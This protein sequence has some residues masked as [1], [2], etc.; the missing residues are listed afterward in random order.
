MRNIYD[1]I[2][3]FYEQEP[4]WDEI[5]ARSHVESYIRQLAW[6]GKS[7]EELNKIWDD[8]TIFSVYLANSE[9]F[10]GDMNRE[11][12]IDCVAW[13]TRNIAGRV[14][15]YET[16]ER[17]LT[18]VEAFYQ[19]LAKKKVVRNQQAISDAKFRMLADNKVNYIDEEGNVL[20]QFKQSNIY[21]TSDL[22][23]KIFMNLGE[24]MSQVQQRMSAFLMDEEYES[25]YSRA[26]W[27][28]SGFMEDNE[29]N[30][31]LDQSGDLAM[32]SLDYYLYDY[33]MLTNDKRPIEVYYESAKAGRYGTFSKAA[34]ELLEILTE[35]RPI[36][37]SI[38]NCLEEG[39]YE[40]KEFFSGE[41]FPLMLPIEGE[42]KVSDFKGVLFY[43]H[44]Y[45]NNTMTT[46]VVQGIL[47]SKEKQD[48]LKRLFLRVKDWFTA[49]E[50]NSGTLEEFFQRNGHLISHFFRFH[51][52][53]NAKTMKELDWLKKY[54]F[55][56][57]IKLNRICEDEVT[58]YMDEQLPNDTFSARDVILA[59]R[60]WTS[61]KEASNVQ[62]QRP[63]IWTG[64]VLWN[65]GGINAMFSI[66]EQVIPNMLD[67]VQM[68]DAGKIVECGNEIYDVLELGDFDPRY[69]NEEGL[70]KRFFTEV[71]V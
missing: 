41:S 4:E 70:L 64:A 1:N 22:P 56:K 24:H 38:E 50:S 45:Y 57:R 17:F 47:M 34:L 62:V 26:E 25:E 68:E 55:E 58:K 35:T 12:F 36:I 29:W 8:I 28:F 67:E 9:N 3:D 31:L 19:Y 46:Q 60:L 49:Q 20:P 7:D 39:L 51:Q 30:S 2:K 65:L 69:L 5:L 42:H 44:I 18:N 32:A 37:F 66:D 27:I 21:P 61:F 40:I 11:N 63:E 43:G 52:R 59:K 33:H 14:A 16:V 6:S 54:E 13:V 23:V 71:L 48:Q 53:I 15:D 10:L